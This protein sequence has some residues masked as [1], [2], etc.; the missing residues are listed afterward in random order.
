MKASRSS[1]LLELLHFRIGQSSLLGVGAF[2][3]P[4]LAA[5]L[6]LT[7]HRAV[8]PR[9]RPFGGLVGYRLG[10]ARAQLVPQF[11]M[12]FLAR[13][14]LNCLPDFPEIDLERGHVIGR[15]PDLNLAI[16]LTDE[17]TLDGIRREV[18]SARA[19]SGNHL[20]L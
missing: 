7:L 5:R 10:I 9:L 13:Y 20:P 18:V 6:G 12:K 16:R 8:S 17:R 2:F 15:R 14:S 3:R 4:C 19:E 11:N 1:W